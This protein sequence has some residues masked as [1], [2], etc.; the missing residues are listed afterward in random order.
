MIAPRATLALLALLGS[1]LRMASA[2]EGKQAA[3]RTEAKKALGAIQSVADPQQR[4]RL[5][6]MSFAESGLGLPAG[7]INVLKAIAEVE[8]SGCAMLLASALGETAMVEKR[9]GRRFSE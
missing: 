2:S 5:A 1:S 6:A 4:G 9:C 7:Q 8:P 3:R